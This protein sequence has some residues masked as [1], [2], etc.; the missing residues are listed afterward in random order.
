MVSCFIIF[1]SL[2]YATTKAVFIIELTI[3]NLHVK[4]YSAQSPS[5]WMIV[6]T[7]Q[8]GRH[9]AWWTGNAVG[10]SENTSLGPDAQKFL[11]SP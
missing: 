7:A 2:L 11:Q 10:E 8:P 5:C 6:L 1:L 4:M 3:I 9:E